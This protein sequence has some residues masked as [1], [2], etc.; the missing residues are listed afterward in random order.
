MNRLIIKGGRVIDPSQGIDKISDIFIEKGKIKAVEENIS[1]ENAEIIDASGKIVTPGLI[2]IHVH[3][4]EP[5]F[6]AKEDIESGSMSAAAGGFTSVACMPNTNPPADNKSVVEFITE[7]AKRVGLVNVYPIGAIS[8]G[9]KGEELSEIGDMKHSGIVGISDDGEPV[10]NSNLMR[11]AL[12]YSSM[13]E[14]PVISHCEDLNMSGEGVINEGLTSTIL[15]MTGIPATAEEIMAARDIRIAEFTGGKLHIAHVSTKGC[16]ELIRQAKAKGINVTA[17]ATP[18]H[19]TLTDESVKTFD[20]NTKVNPP[21][22]TAEDV[23]AVRQGLKDGTIDAIVTDHAP[24]TIEDKEVEYDYASFGISGLETSLPLVITYLVNTGILTLSQ[25]IEK[26][27]INPANIINVPKGTLKPGSDADIT[28]I[29][30]EK[31]ITVDTKKFKSKGKNSP[32][33]GWELKGSVAMTIKS[34]NIVY[35]NNGD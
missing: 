9:L 7:K 10:M 32:F 34:G 27:T 15:G 18:H 8:K 23:E 29:D 1:I 16:V 4:R 20:T 17:E 2:D 31:S 30:I 26:M 5:G 28:I 11:R 21:L 24:H 14:L 19:F 13:F 22:R 25:A 33:N 35:K 6:E 12:E 3:L